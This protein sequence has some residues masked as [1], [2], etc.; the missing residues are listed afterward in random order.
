MPR[1]ANQ[2][3]SDP[4]PARPLTPLGGDN[5]IHFKHHQPQ[6]ST[7]RESG[8]GPNLESV[9][10]VV[11]VSAPIRTAPATAPM[12]HLRFKAGEHETQ[13]AI[14]WGL[15]GVGEDPAGDLG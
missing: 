4:R 2:G 5:R 15:L 6:K 8:A 14:H 13:Q 12:R 7:V 1:D 10:N 9:G 11:G 3:Q